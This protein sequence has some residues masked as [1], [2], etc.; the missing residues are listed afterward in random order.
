M[1]ERNFHL[2]DQ[3]VATPSALEFSAELID[4][5]LAR[6]NAAEA[7]SARRLAEQRGG[8]GPP[9]P[10]IRGEASRRPGAVDPDDASFADSAPY[11]AAFVASSC[12]TK[13]TLVIALSLI[14]KWHPLMTT[15]AGTSACSSTYGSK[16]ALMSACS[17][18]SERSF[19][20]DR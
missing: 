3:A 13:A 8:G 4:Q 11:L 19:R 6:Q 12:S 16:I 14:I 2:D 9:A 1:G 5:N 7:L 20:P 18:V 15:R 17:G 10:S